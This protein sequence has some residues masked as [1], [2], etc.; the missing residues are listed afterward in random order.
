MIFEPMPRE[1][2][3]AQQTPGRIA[4]LREKLADL[5]E[6]GVDRVLCVRFDA[7]FAALDAPSFIDQILV[8][9]LGLR[10]LVVGDDFRFGQGRAGDFVLLQAAG[11]ERGFRVESLPAFC[12]E[13]ERVSSTR[14]REALAQGEMQ[15]AA[16]LLGRSY[17]IEGR[18]VGGQRLGR[19]LGVPTA[20]LRLRERRAVRYGIYAARVSAPGIEDWPAAVSLG[21]RPSVPGDDCLLEAHLLDFDGDLYG[22]R[23]RVQLLHYLRPEQR[24][25][26]LEGLRRQMNVDIAQARAWLGS[27]H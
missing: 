4:S 15:R 12:M 20:N 22:R 1:F 13:G 3:A 24:F 18:V 11:G 7:R 6:A 27:H 16:H 8:R 26:D 23:I 2:F 14:V 19:A 10:Y 9:G 21:V 17:R 25:A 5:A